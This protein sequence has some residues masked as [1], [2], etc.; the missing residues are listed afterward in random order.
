M[1]ILNDKPFDHTCGHGTIVKAMRCDFVGGVD[2]YPPSHL[3]YNEIASDMIELGAWHWA[4]IVPRLN[5]FTG[6]SA[7]EVRVHVGE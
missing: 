1:E 3:T 2:V 6:G 5:G 7:L 4:N